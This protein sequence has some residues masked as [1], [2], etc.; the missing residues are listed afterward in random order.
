MVFVGVFVV[1]AVVFGSGACHSEAHGEN[2]ETLHGWCCCFAQV[3]TQNVD[4]IP[5]IVA[6][7]FSATSRN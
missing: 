2:R 6:I 4:E 1:G 3:Q 5:R 7:L